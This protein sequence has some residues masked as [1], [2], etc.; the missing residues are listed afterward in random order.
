MAKVNFDYLNIFKEPPLMVGLLVRHFFKR[1]GSANG[2]ALVVNTSLIGEFAASLPALHEFIKE[3][4]GKQI[5][6][7]VSPPLKPLAERIRGVHAVYTA[8]SV[9]GRVLEDQM[10]EHSPLAGEYEKAIVM[11][12]SPDSYR[13]LAR[14]TT[15]HLKTSL[16]PMTAYGLHMGWRLLVGKTPK[17]RREVN[18]AMFSSPAKDVAFEDIF[19]F[20]ETDYEQ[21]Q[22]EVP[23]AALP[24]KLI[25]HT[26]ASWVTN[27][28]SN[29][30]WVELLRTLPPLG[31]EIIFVGSNRDK[32]DY[33]FI[34]SQL[35]FPIHSQIEQMSLVQ[36]V[37]LL[38]TSQYFIGVDSGPRNFAHVCDLPS[39]TL[40]GPGPHMYTP[41]N[42]RDI[43]LDR[44]GGRGL[45]QRFISKK[46]ALFIERITPQ[47]VV[48]AFA[49]LSE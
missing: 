40:L 4:P 11:R 21:L 47:D 22:K 32:A 42:P 8:K 12:I 49:R 34:A 15:K 31:Y 6:L 14:V 1:K 24:N 29:N 5:D 43:T 46:G 36:L 9:F 2:R 27:R 38:R 39:I 7:M 18:F 13:T 28:W 37:L 35:D 41:P 3:N 33:D 17:S 20:T 45:Y 19:D 26:G 25:I 48:D 10:H 44:S 23:L 30:N 16:L